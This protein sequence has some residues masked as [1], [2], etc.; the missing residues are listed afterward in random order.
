MAESS[1]SVL[2]RL[3]D[4]GATEALIIE[5]GERLLLRDGM[6]GVNVQ[7]VAAE[8]G[9]DRKLVYR[10]FDGAD[11]VVEKVAARAHAA[12]ARD[13]DAIPPVE[14]ATLRAFARESL[15]AWLQALRDNAVVLRLMAWAVVDDTEQMRRL[16]ADRSAVLQAWM[17]QRRPRLKAPPAGDVT[18]FNAVLL[19]AVQ[20]LVLAGQ[21]RGAFGGV[22]LDEAG[23]LRIEAALDALLTAFPD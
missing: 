18:A 1:V 23:W 14:A 6:G 4:R 22:P 17:R 21:G 2:G 3:R 13:L 8:A 11:G 5:A 10:Y 20:H 19:A 12:L 7:T 9:C 16:E 15:L